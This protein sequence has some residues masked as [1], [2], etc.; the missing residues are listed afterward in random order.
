MNRRTNKDLVKKKRLTVTLLQNKTSV[1][2]FD[3][4][5]KKI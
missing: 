5:T 1:T 3:Y 4:I 2:N